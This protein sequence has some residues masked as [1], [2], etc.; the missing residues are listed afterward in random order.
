MADRMFGNSHF[1][2]TVENRIEIGENENNENQFEYISSIGKM[3][4]RPELWQ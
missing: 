3:Y 2:F 4:Y 1:G